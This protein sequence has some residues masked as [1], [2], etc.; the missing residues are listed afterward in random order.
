MATSTPDKDKMASGT[1]L[2]NNIVQPYPTRTPLLGKGSGHDANTGVSWPHVKF[3]QAVENGV[4]GSV[5]I[6]Q[7]IPASSA[8]PGVAGTE[9]YDNATGTLYKC[10]AA[11]SWFKFVGAPF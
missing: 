9:V 1:V 6:A 7:Q 5:Q 8:S 4:N 2:R 3:F 10:M 11:N